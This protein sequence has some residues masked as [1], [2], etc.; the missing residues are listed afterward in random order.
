MV[1][2][3][4]CWV[5]LPIHVVSFWLA[6]ILQPFSTFQIL[7]NSVL[8]SSIQFSAS[9][10]VYGG[11]IQEPLNNIMQTMSLHCSIFSISEI[12]SRHGQKGF[13]STYVS[14]IFEIEED[15][16]CWHLLFYLWSLP[17]ILPASF[18][19]EPKQ[20]AHYAIL[21]YHTESL[22]ISKTGP[23]IAWHLHKKW[24]WIT[25]EPRICI[26]ARNAK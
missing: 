25:F 3:R 10:D 4:S 21:G 5:P 13:S 23:C 16:S 2:M 8:S 11:S 1:M 18:D 15:I 12:R 14:E 24:I 6:P 17:W 9:V 19:Q 7:C 26:A 20:P 22:G